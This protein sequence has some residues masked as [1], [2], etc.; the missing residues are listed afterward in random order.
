[1]DV[2]VE[3]LCPY[4]RKYVWESFGKFVSA[5][6]EADRIETLEDVNLIFHWYGN[7]VEINFEDGRKGFYC[8]HGENEC[9]GNRLLN[10][11]QNKYYSSLQD[12]LRM[13]E[14]TTCWTQ[15]IG[16]FQDDAYKTA[17]YCG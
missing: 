13:W 5:I 3:A 17:K 9:R 12:R 16:R 11:A 7:V 14:F 8:H 10:C 15:Y 6:K 4:S 1:M 2:F